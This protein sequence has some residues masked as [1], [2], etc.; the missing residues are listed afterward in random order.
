MI[1]KDFL[2]KYKNNQNSVWC[3][4][5]KILNKIGV[6]ALAGVVQWA[7]HQP[8]DW[9]ITGSVPSQGT[10]LGYGPGPQLGECEKQPVSV[11][12]A[13]QCFSPSLPPVLSL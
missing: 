7:K 6:L 2:T 9:N 12:L 10:C 4:Y 8:V 11:T 5:Y 13:H 1:Y 3:L